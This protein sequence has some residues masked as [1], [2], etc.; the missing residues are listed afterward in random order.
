M[1]KCFHWL[2]VSVVSFLFVFSGGVNTVLA[3]SSGL[4]VSEINF[5]DENLQECVNRDI[6]DQYADEVVSFSC[7]KLIQNI[8]GIE[9]FRNL[10]RLFFGTGEIVDISLL[11]SLTK[12]EK[13]SIP[14]NKITNIT[15][16][17]SLNNLDFLELGYNEIIDISPLRSLNNLKY[18]GFSGNKITNISPLT[19]L[20]NL[21]DLNLY[22]KGLTEIS[23]L[24]SLSDLYNLSLEGNPNILCQDLDQLALDL[25]TTNIRRPASCESP[26]KIK[27]AVI[28]AEPS[29]LGFDP[30]HGKSYYETN[31]LPDVKDYWCEQSF[32]ARDTNGVCSGGLVDLEF[33]VFDNNGLN[34]KLSKTNFYYGEGNAEEEKHIEFLND[35]SVMSGIYNDDGKQDIITVIHPGYSEQISKDDKNMGTLAYG[36]KLTALV[37]EKDEI[38]AWLHEI[39]HIIGNLKINKTLCDIYSRATGCDTYGGD[40][41]NW[42]LMGLLKKPVALTSF[43]KKHLNW[44]GEEIINKGDHQV[45]ALSAMQ[46]GDKIKRYNIN[47]DSYYLLETRTNDPRFS[48]WDS[49]SIPESALLTYQVRND[50]VGDIPFIEKVNVEN[51]FT[52]DNPFRSL[53]NNVKIDAYATESNEIGA[54]E[55]FFHT[56]VD[57]GNA[58]SPQVPTKGATLLPNHKIL[59]QIWDDDPEVFYQM[60]T[61]DDVPM[62]GRL[63]LESIKKE[64]FELEMYLIG[65]LIT[66]LISGILFYMKKKKLWKISFLLSLI[67]IVIFYTKVAPK[68]YS[69]NYAFKNLIHDIKLKTSL[70]KPN[71]DYPQQ[72]EGGPYFLPIEKNETLDLDLHAITPEGLHVGINYETGEYENNIPNAEA[73]GDLLYNEEWIFVPDE[74]EVEFYVSSHD[75]EEYLEANPEVI[76]QLSSTDEGYTLQA[77]R[78]NND[79]SRHESPVLEDETIAPGL[80]NTYVF[81]GSEIE[82]VSVNDAPLFDFL[83][84]TAET[85][86]VDKTFDITWIDEDTEDD[87]TIKI[88]YDTDD[89]GVDGI[90]VTSEVFSEDDETD[91]FTWDTSNIE[92][93]DYFLYAVLDDGINDLVTVYSEYA[94]DIDHN[95]KIK[96]TV[97][98]NPKKLNVKS[99]GKWVKGF[100][101]L[102][103]E[104]DVNNIN[105]KRVKF[106]VNGKRIKA[107]QKKSKGGDQNKNGIPDLM[108]RFDRKAVQDIVEL[109]KNRVKI[110]GKIDGQVF[111]GR[112]KLEVI[113]K[114]KKN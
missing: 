36:N 86:K 32:G 56:K 103:E 76:S 41:E 46:Y 7:Y 40:I 82:I 67:L 79:G 18:L 110:R 15:P 33:E 106:V 87:A 114:K 12:L 44:L 30:T 68:E 19:G 61:S 25:P 100:I 85:E 20:N 26:N 113:G 11:G 107:D 92:E 1:Q 77:V 13:L 31:I 34:Y 29:D 37:A 52:F 17:R 88:Y 5:P 8:E 73:S 59:N 16:L 6:H 96:A 21:T 66:F 58:L 54:E 3:Q 14:V 93:G 75:I 90:L 84:P 43:S 102:P 50:V 39:G 23:S 57:I 27:V 62:S 2:S 105:L 55:K 74:T 104:F 95:E 111:R 22:N 65:I 101:E 45:K 47:D 69:T 24:S 9:S 94:L 38:H 35:V 81:S 72:T 71:L 70:I 48:K 64:V 97:W 78:Y 89:V 10:K 98:M 108:V 99:H 91:Q 112:T 49:A 4:L 51:L 80:E 28:L 63:S 83:T 60:I 53:W 109:G 42:A